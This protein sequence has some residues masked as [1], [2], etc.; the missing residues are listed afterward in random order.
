MTKLSMAIVCE[1]STG[2]KKDIVAVF[3]KTIAD[4]P[5]L[6]VGDQ[7]VVD[8]YIIQDVRS[9]Y[10]DVDDQW[11]EIHLDD[12]TFSEDDHDEPKAVIDLLLASGWDQ[13]KTDTEADEAA[14][15]E[16]RVVLSSAR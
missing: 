3:R 9:R 5:S 11:L 10:Y 14:A 6:H 16:A 8:D 15:D 2:Q 1:S 13:Y 7:V 4:A 12:F